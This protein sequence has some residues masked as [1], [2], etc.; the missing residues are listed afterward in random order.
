MAEAIVNNPQSQQSKEKNKLQK[1]HAI[2]AG[3]HSIHY[4]PP[5]TF[6]VLE[7]IHTPIT[8][9]HSKQLTQNLIDAADQIVV[10]D[11]SIDLGPTIQKPVER[12]DIRDP[13]RESI[14]VFREVRDELLRKITQFRI[15][16]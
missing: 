8:A 6:Q 16:K 2:S 5:H 13:Y 15:D 4:I 7:E 11:K 3:V 12:W 14:D 10:L 1:W 9:L